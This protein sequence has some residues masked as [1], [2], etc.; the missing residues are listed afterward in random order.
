M[1]IFTNQLRSIDYANPQEALKVMANHI[2]NIQEQLEY[3]LMNLDSSNVTELDTNKTNIGSSTGGVSVTGT[4]IMLNGA[5]GESF[6]AGTRSGEKV[7][8]FTLNGAGGDQMMYLNDKG[9]LVIT[10]NAT[11]TVDGGTW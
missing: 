1:P 2:R 7:F 3:T 9:Q 4:A 10:R 6:E 11:I 8:R 5:S